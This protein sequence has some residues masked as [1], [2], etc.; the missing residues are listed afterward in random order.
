[1]ATDVLKQIE[2]LFENPD[3]FS[4]ENMEKLVNET[5]TFFN[6]MKIKLESPDQ[7]VREEALNVASQLKAKLEEQAKTLCKS[8][9]MDPAA[10]ESY[11][12]TPNNFSTDEWQAMENAK[13]EIANYK[14][15]L[16]KMETGEK[17]PAARARKKRQKAVKEWIVG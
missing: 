13:T 10:L 12:N 9:G 2:E 17:S 4:P 1:M 15:S 8:I 6:D 5:V 16:A 11:I 3:Q 7:K 14:A